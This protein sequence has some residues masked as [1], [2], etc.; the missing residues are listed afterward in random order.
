MFR[1]TCNLSLEI[2]ILGCYGQYGAFGWSDGDVNFQCESVL[3]LWIL[4]RQGHGL[5]M[6]EPRGS[7][8]IFFLA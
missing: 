6:G 4:D 5:G 1:T 8:S 3:Q 7:G 2:F